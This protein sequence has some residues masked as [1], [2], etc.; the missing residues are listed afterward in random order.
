[1]H[2]IIDFLKGAVKRGPNAALHGSMGCYNFG[3]GLVT[4]RNEAMQ[5]GIM[6]DAEISFI[7]PA[8]EFEA[9]LARMKSV[10]AMGFNNQTLTLKGGRLKATIQCIDELPLA[11]PEMP[12]DWFDTPSGFA[13]ALKLAL[14][15]VNDMGW[16]SGIRLMDGRITAIT[17]TAG[18]DITLP[19]LLLN[20]PISLPKGAT[21]FLVAQGTPN[22]YMP[23]GGSVMFKWADGRWLNAQLLAAGFP[24]SIDGIFEKANVPE[25]LIELTPEWRE[26]FAD[27][28]ALAESAVDLTGTHLSSGKGAA[29]CEIEIETSVP[30]DHR[31]RWVVK[32][33]Q[34]V[35]DCATHWAPAMYPAPAQFVGPNLRGVVMGIK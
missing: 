33:L 17:N 2:D 9:I 13:D 10:T 32:T 21:E 22:H 30:E 11:I 34:P 7:V 23:M 1:M 31:S 26:A 3:S 5:A 8:D 28:A 19:G 35:L 20:E 14:P 6:L 4:S 27:A 29:G 12:E 25:L 16:N 18:I 15:F 24:P